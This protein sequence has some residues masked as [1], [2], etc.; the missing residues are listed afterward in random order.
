M[1][2]MISVIA[3]AAISTSASAFDYKINLEGRADFNNLTTTTT[4]RATG[5]ES[6]ATSN[7]FLSSLVR[8]NM[9][10]AINENLTYRMRYRLNAEGTTQARDA[11]TT[12]LDYLYID[13]KNSMFT[14]RFGKMDWSEAFG[15]ESFVPTTDTF[16]SSDAYAAYNTNIGRYRFGVSA[17]A[18]F[19]ETQKLTLAISNPNSAI[20]DTVG[21]TNNKSLALAAHYSSVMFDKMFQP[22]LSYTY[23]PQDGDSNAVTPTKTQAYTMMAAGWKTEAM[24]LG[25][26]A[27]WKQFNKKGRT[28]TSA[29][30][31]G[32]TTS[33]FA[34]AS[35]AIN[36]FTPFIQYVNDKFKGEVATGDYKKNSFA[37]GTMYK[38]FADTNFR[39]HVLYTNANKKFD[40]VAS[41]STKIKDNKITIG[42][43]IDI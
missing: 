24:G 21:A 5:A 7:G 34:N 38:P 35:Y 9:V 26:E 41:T 17:I 6:K 22:T 10:G 1:K 11:A 23:A 13:H 39:Y 31:D 30:A 29:A 20:T 32:K 40:N 36:S 3:L 19:M 27:D 37:I 15:R 16:V 18:T 12:A 8:L 2:K 33:M 42:M 4:N 25:F 28:A 43:K 14:T